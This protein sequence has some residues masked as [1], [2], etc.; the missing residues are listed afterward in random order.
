ML[1]R[2]LLKNLDY[3]LLGLVLF[4]MLAS[5]VILAS[6]SQS[7][8]LENGDPW[9][10]VKRQ[11]V[12]IVAGLVAMALVL[13]VDYHDLARLSTAI[14]VINLALLAGVLVAGREALGASR[15]LRIGPFDFQPSEFAKL[16]I[17]L[18]L[19]NHL[20]SREG[21]LGEWR[22]LVPPF[23]HI[24]IPM[25][26]VLKQPDLGTSM[27]FLAI[28]FGMLFMAGAPIGRLLG[29][30][31]GGLTV[32]VSWILLHLAFPRVIPIPLKDYQLKRLIVFINPNLAPLREGYHIIQSK[33]AV[34]SGRILGKG[35]FAGTQNQLNYL[36]EQHTDFIFS[37]IGEELGFVGA[38]LLL[39]IYFNILWRGIYAAS[40]ARD[41]YG[42]LLVTGV[43]SMLT[44]HVL[45]NVGMTIGIM[46]VTGIPLPFM[47]YGGS[48]L[49]N[50]AVAVGL[51]L[52]VY[53]RRQ[54]I[55]F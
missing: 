36:P 6:A 2:R 18:T 54:K 5:L 23:L 25:L 16:A 7:T 14:Y 29:L 38:T 48:S 32:A 27:V 26:L 41:L 50:N 55:L 3:H 12:W 21:K 8:G 34:G 17:I 22:D 11:A 49:L 28:L 4:L 37:V 19:A 24:G 33:I 39:V 30:A 20:A 46:P 52:N 53:M 43:V 51:L 15:W 31:A 1:E 42:S 45:V 40:Q 35:L 13:T 10:F 9:F 47:S 44:F